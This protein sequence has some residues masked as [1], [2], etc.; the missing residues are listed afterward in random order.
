MRISKQTLSLLLFLFYTILVLSIESRP[1]AHYVLIPIFLALWILIIFIFFLWKKDGGFPL[2]DAGFFCVIFVSMYTLIPL[3]NFY[4][5]GFSFGE[6][7]DRRLQYY[8]PSAME[9][10][11]FFSNHIIYLVSLASSY[12]LCRRRNKWSPTLAIED[13]SA[14]TVNA[15]FII[16]L[17]L[18]IYF[19]FFEYV[20][21]LG[22]KSGYGDEE[23]SSGSLLVQQI[24]GKLAGIHYVFTYVALAILILNKR[25]IRAASLVFVIL[26]WG[27]LDAF[28]AFGSRGALM[29]LLLISFTLWYR[30]HGVNVRFAFIFL[31]LFFLI[32]TFI[33]LVRPFANIQDFGD[34]ITSFEGF[35]SSTNEFQSLL[36]TSYDVKMLLENGVSVPIG[37]AFNDI[38]PL[39]PPQQIW[40]FTKLTGADWYLTQIGQAGTGVGFMWGVIT[41]SLIGFG[42]LELAV[43]GVFLGWLLA[44]FHQCYQ[45]HQTKLLPN[46][47]YILVCLSTISTFRDTTGAIFW[48]IFWIFLPSAAILWLFGSAKDLKSTYAK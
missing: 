24:N 40:P 18:T 17:V 28:I 34:S 23:I 12:V 27:I 43:R 41:Q 45:R 2:L 8:A 1:D 4:F 14:R 30:F 33:G 21:G 20:L 15:V 37:L 11:Y 13:P 39:A 36:G 9:L 10:G 46:V 47:F 19:A 3:L 31:P 16:F 6:L 44:K 48:D 35:A 25:D 42:S 29:L 22:F 32:F 26:T 38:M 7:S 5:G